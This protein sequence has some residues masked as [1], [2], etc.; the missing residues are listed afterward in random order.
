MLYHNSHQLNYRRPFGALPCGTAVRL[1]VDVDAE[2]PPELIQLRLWSTSTGEQF[3]SLHWVENRET[4]SVFEA[5]VLVPDKPG[6]LWYHFIARYADHTIWYGAPVD[7]LGGAG[8]ES[9]AVPTDWQITVYDPKA[10]VPEWYRNGIVY[11]IF[12]DRFYRGD[13]A[14]PLPQLQPGNLFHPHWNDRP[15]YTKDPTT[16]NIV[17][18]DF[19]GG[20]LQGVRDKL[21]YIKELGADTIYLNPIFESVSNHKYDTG[22]YKRIDEG[23]GG[24]AAFDAL[25]ATANQMGLRIIL[26]GVFSH[27]GSDSPYFKDAVRSKDS[28][29]F[30]WYRFDKHPDSYDCWWGVTTLPNV[31]EMDSAYRRF[32]ISDR[33]S[34]IKHWVKRGISGWRLDVVD[35]LPGEFVQEMFDEL[36]KE[37]KEAVLIGEVWEDASRK[38]SY[39]KLREYL[40]GRELDAVINYPFRSAILDFLTEQ[41]T[42]AEA[43][44]RLLSICENYPPVY[45]LS[46]LNVLGSHDVPRVLTLLGGAPQ[47]STLTPLAQ[48]RY[49]L[50]AES[51]KEGLAKLRTAA[52]IQF[53]MPGVPCV[54]YGDE[55]GLEG[56]SDP[57]NR[58]TYPW[59]REQADLIEWYKSLSAMRRKEPVLVG[60]TWSSLDAG[61]DVLGYIR[62]SEQGKNALGEVMEDG[63]ILAFANR[64]GETL[65][66]EVNIG[67]ANG[68]AFRD[69]GFTRP[70]EIHAADRNGFLKVSITGHGTRLLKNG[71]HPLFSKRTAGIL[72]HPTSLPGPYGIGD[73]GSAAYKF[74]EWLVQAKQGW[75]QVLPLNP[76][77]YTG[78]P[79][80]SDSAFAG[81]TDLISPD[82]LLADGYLKRI[83]PLAGH[84]GSRVEFLKVREWKE[85]M[86]RE[87]FDTFQNRRKPDDYERFLVTA[88]CWL[89]DYCLFLALKKMNGG[90]AWATWEKAA[91]NRHAAALTEYRKKLATE[92]SYQCF[93]QYVLFTQW[94][95]LRQFA[96]ERGVRIM[97]DLPMFVAHDSSDVWANPELF[98]LDCKGFPTTVAGVP[99]DYFC[100]NGQLWGNPHY[101]CERHA[102]EDFSWW[103]RRFS[104]LMRMTDA[105]RIDHFRGFEAC[106]EVPAKNKTARHGRWVP[107]P[108]RELFLALN[109]QLGPLPLLAEDLGVITPEVEELRDSF[110]FPGMNVAQF[111]LFREGNKFHSPTPQPNTVC[112]TGTH[113]N[114]TLLGWLLSLQKSD[115]AL[116]ADV[117]QWANLSATVETKAGVNAIIKKL[118]ETGARTVIV[119][120]QDWLG[121]DS[122][123]RM[124]KPGTTEGNWVWRMPNDSL[125]SELAA[126][127]A[128][129]VENSARR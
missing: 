42:A 31:N 117:F 71:L 124:N 44:R 105:I 24:N 97:G 119:P 83:G 102:A 96:N 7:T 49:D 50:S 113:D 38:E 114:D 92:I 110:F 116:L 15:F 85:I 125:T 55:A 79:Y 28:P 112:Y 56:F 80:Q 54:Y 14:P 20:T 23:F 16:G 126:T 129:Y 127:V 10:H 58:R 35:E 34:V 93:V 84:D 33:D 47:E 3:Q 128:E 48:A 43:S 106:W 25:I 2:R 17:A 108:G 100:K 37:N 70:L 5:V 115:P 118:M 63:T 66:C 30:S 12:V 99:P 60:G 76:A 109:H 90:A 104:W 52:F 91:A 1:L 87:A 21:T 29:F 122:S 68:G 64:T 65:E 88:N 103:V 57:Q 4:V 95:R 13:Q 6:L 81:N 27:T 75:W 9:G 41:A 46:A 82:S 32:I 73:L 107:G 36:K 62:K 69:I 8:V 98:A 89:D 22:D 11:Q 121:L 18:Y 94:D 123:A 59:G 77:D 19:F 40:W 61:P 26:D 51:R 78:S 53:T 74:V 101:V 72:L 86:L 120:L 39:G 45:L 111:T 67:A